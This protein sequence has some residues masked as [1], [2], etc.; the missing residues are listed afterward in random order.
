LGNEVVAQA[1]A[2]VLISPTGAVAVPLPGIA[3]R[4]PE[5]GDEGAAAEGLAQPESMEPA[6]VPF[7]EVPVSE[8]PAVTTTE[9]LFLPA[10]SN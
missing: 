1:A 10:L 8:S 3:L 5:A 9:Q 6:P 4:L 7:A 2:T